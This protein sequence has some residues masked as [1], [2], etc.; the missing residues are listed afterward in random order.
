MAAGSVRRF[1]PRLV[2]SGHDDH[3]AKVSWYFDSAEWGLEL[4]ELVGPGVG[5]RARRPRPAS[6]VSQTTGS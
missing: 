2:R 3:F 6:G 5:R 1:F 4:R